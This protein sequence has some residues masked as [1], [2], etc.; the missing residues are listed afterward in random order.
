MI[1]N[2]IYLVKRDIIFVINIYNIH[3]LIMWIGKIKKHFKKL[4]EIK[5]STLLSFFFVRSVE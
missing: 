1:F 2:S 5:Y 4:N 3:F